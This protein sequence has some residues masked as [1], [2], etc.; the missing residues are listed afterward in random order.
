MVRVKSSK[1]IV[2]IIVLLSISAFSLSFFYNLNQSRIEQMESLM[3]R[4][5]QAFLDS[6]LD[7]LSAGY[8]QW[9][10]MYYAL[11]QDDHDFLDENIED[12]INL[13]PLFSDVNLR[14]ADYD[15]DEPFEVYCDGTKMFANLGIYDDEL[16]YK[17]K[18]KFINVTVDM[19]SLLVITHLDA[20]FEY[21][22][23]AFDGIEGIELKSKESI[24]KPGH[25]VSAAAIGT[26]SMLLMHY[27]YSYSIKSH[28]EIE[29]LEAIVEMLSHKDKYTAEHSKSVADI[30]VRIAKRM[31]L[32]RKEVRA[33]FKA[34]HL[35]DIGKI[36]IPE[37]IL[38]KEGRLTPEEYSIIKKHPEIGYEIVSQFP[39]LRKVAEIVRSHHE[40]LNG[41]GYPDGMK[42]EQIPISSQV[43]TVADI[44]EA[45]ISDRPY[46][47][48][49][50]REEA[51]KILED[52]AI[53]QK[54]VKILKAE[55]LRKS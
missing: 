6:S 13:S 22:H 27:L 16:E 10:D 38:N 49:H 1:W 34:G 43:L 3:G 54:V 41:S 50:T 21:E 2:S 24:L 23:N 31:H 53:N 17:L 9:D 42:E 47:K 32:P 14:N 35:H 11:E 46:R 7:G 48:G 18:D 52:L 8:F 20:L 51:F 19:E 15:N 28:F 12:I 25:Y 37:R 26:L 40:M 29:G 5:I 45:L 33:L 55:E 30:A 4:S 39:N 44:Y 36:G